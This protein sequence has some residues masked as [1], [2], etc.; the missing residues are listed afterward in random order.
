MKSWE[1]CKKLQQFNKKQAKDGKLQIYKVD[2]ISELHRPSLQV[3]KL[4]LITRGLLA[5]Q[6]DFSPVAEDYF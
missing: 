6:I 3:R 1:S 2:S 5:A 4:F